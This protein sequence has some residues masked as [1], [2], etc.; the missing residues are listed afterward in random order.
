MGGQ[1]MSLEIGQQFVIRNKSHEDNGQRLTV[2]RYFVKRMH[3]IQDDYRTKMVD[4]FIYSLV[5]EKR[6][7]YRWT[8]QDINSRI[9]DG[10]LVEA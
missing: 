4:T 3:R 10:F 6:N 8:E 2:M 9:R 7:E 1:R 5:S